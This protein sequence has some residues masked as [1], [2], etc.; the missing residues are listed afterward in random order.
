MNNRIKPRRYKF[1]TQLHTA[2]FF[3]ILLFNSIPKSPIHRHFKFFVILKIMKKESKN[4]AFIDAQNVHLSIKRLGWEIDW[5]RFRV[6]L[7]E[8]FGVK[9][10]Q[11]F[12]GLVPG[13]TALYQY[14]Q[15][16][17]FELVF[18][19]TIELKDGNRKGNVDAELV[20]SAAAIEFINYDKAV[21]VSGD[22]DFAYLVDFL[23]KREK[24]EAIIVPDEHKY[25]A[26]LK[27]YSTP[28][29]NVIYFINRS[30]RLLERH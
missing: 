8:R 24:L 19:D 13:N 22:G 10:A 9:K 23:Q 29:N 12:I 14:L 16:A 30:R 26:L 25:S 15:S 21:I 27:K 7:N 6:F 18:K 20:L 4:Y 11:L 5:R 1:E 2:F 17:G 28:D 3:Y